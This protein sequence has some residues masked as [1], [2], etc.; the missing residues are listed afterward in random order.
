MAMRETQ[1]IEDDN[2]E[3]DENKVK[4]P[5]KLPSHLRPAGPV[6]SVEA[7]DQALKRLFG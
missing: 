1:S 7:A 6:D 3:S 5:G 2:E 4:T